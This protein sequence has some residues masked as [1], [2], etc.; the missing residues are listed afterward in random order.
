MPIKLQTI[1]KKYAVVKIA[2]NN[3][4]IFLIVYKQAFVYSS[5]ILSN[6]LN[7]F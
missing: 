5:N 2:K 7:Y 6:W 1:W 3:P 4:Y